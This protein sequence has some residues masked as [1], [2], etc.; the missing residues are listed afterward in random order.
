MRTAPR[1]D[2]CARSNS[3]EAPAGLIAAHRLPVEETMAAYGAER[4]GAGP[5]ELFAAVQGDWYFRTRTLH[6]AAVRGARPRPAG[7]HTYEFARRSPAYAGRLGACHGLAV[8]VRHP[9]GGRR[10]G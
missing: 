6:A 4:P 3:F 9:P 8:R 10:P 2:R 7:T 1:R 5:G